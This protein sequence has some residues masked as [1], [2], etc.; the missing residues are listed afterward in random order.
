MDGEW[1]VYMRKS[2]EKE[3]R[4][5]KKNEIQKEREIKFSEWS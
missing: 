2:Y 5:R 3:K 1:M 4:E